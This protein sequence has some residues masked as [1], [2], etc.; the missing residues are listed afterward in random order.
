M[1]S[2][3]VSISSSEKINNAAQC[4]MNET[5]PSISKERYF[6]SYDAFEEW[7]KKNGAETTCE[8][9]MLAYF[10]EMSGDK[11]PSTLWAYYSMLKTVIKL[12]ENVNIGDY[13]QLVAF[14]KRKSEG[15]KPVK[16][17][18]L[19]DFELKRFIAE[20]DDGLWLDVKVRKCIPTS[21]R[22]YKS[23]IFFF[24]FRLSVFSESAVRYEGRN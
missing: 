6:K 5:L 20:A 12:K 23:D 21:T 14:L 15:Y 10:Y 19:A 8:T 9:V 18:T 13:H 2:D 11:K 4:A 7:K 22:S 3:S 17:K 16:A 24:L 1:D